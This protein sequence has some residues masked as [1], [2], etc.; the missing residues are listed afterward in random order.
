MGNFD[1][2]K[3]VSMAEKKKIAQ[4]RNI[5]KIQEEEFYASMK[6]HQEK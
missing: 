2:Q 1:F 3:P 5:R 4:D 6:A